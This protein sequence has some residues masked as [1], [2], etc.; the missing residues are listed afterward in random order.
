MEK[1]IYKKK[2]GQ[3]F[4][5][6][7]IVL[8][9]IIKYINLKGNDLIVEIGPGGGALTKKLK[10]LN[11]NILAYEIDNTL[12]SKL[13]LLV[14]EKTH[15][16]YDDFLKRDIEL[17]LKKYK[18]TNLLLVANLPYNI[19]TPIIEK[20]FELDTVF[21]EIIIMIQDEVAHRI[22]SN[23]GN[24]MYGAFTAL[25][26]FFY[27]KK[28]LFFVSR[29][30]FYPS[31]NVDSA[32]I[33]LTRKKSVLKEKYENYK[34]FIYDAFKYKRKTL[35][36]NLKG[37][38]LEIIETIL[39]KYNLSLNDRAESVSSSIFIEIVNSLNK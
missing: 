34:S 32:V 14:S 7:E 12:K 28:Y 20:V 16:I 30:S 4:L 23:S 27:D 33:K 37:Y 10:K 24:K 3:N 21:N 36:N 5:R 29:D 38:N 22:C 26:D 39:K 18:Y 9:N 35:R 31:P 13:N 17:D 11:T 25:I 8:D 2:Y 1:F 15:I 19:T 6:D